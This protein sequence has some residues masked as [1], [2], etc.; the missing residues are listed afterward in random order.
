MQSC[1][2]DIA[3]PATTALLKSIDQTMNGSTFLLKVQTDTLL[4]AS[5]YRDELNHFLRSPLFQ[6]MMLE[7]DQQRGLDIYTRWEISEEDMPVMYL[8]SG[9][10]LKDHFALVFTPMDERQF[11]KRLCWILREAFNPYDI[12]T[13]EKQTQELMELPRF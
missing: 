8:P 6:T 11:A 5:N 9:K 13:T 4:T 1:L 3:K 2:Q 12:H 10:F 7:M